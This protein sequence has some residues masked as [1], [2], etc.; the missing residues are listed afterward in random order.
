MGPFA[1]TRPPFAHEDS[2]SYTTCCHREQKAGKWLQIYNLL[3]A[4]EKDRWADANSQASVHP[5][6]KGRWAVAKVPC[7]FPN[8]FNCTKTCSRYVW[9]CGKVCLVFAHIQKGSYFDEVKSMYT[10]SNVCVCGD[11]KNWRLQS[12]TLSQARIIIIFLHSVQTHNV[13]YVHTRHISIKNKIHK[14]F[15]KTSMLRSMLMCQNAL[16][17]GKGR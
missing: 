2:G 15:F 16:T 3:S 9:V 8:C 1:T 14:I 17:I 12:T 6:V 13:S 5:Q 7:V 10:M 11:N 4:R